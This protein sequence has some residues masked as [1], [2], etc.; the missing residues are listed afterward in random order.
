[1]LRIKKIILLNFFSLFVLANVTAQSISGVVYED[2]NN[3]GTKEANEPGI[4]GVSVSDQINIVVTD[5]NGFY[6]IVNKGYGIIFITV[7]NGYSAKTF[8]QKTSQLQINFALTKSASHSSFQFIHASDTHLSENSMDRMDKFRSVIDSVHP[9]LV[10]ITGDLVK[11]ALRVGEKEAT[12]LYELFISEA[13]K[14]KA[15]LWLAPGN[16]EIFGIERHLS[17][18]SPLNPL[19]GRK[20]Y[21]NYLGPDY[22]SFNY[23]G[24]HFIALNSLEFEDLYYYGRIDSTQMEWLKK[25]LSFLDPSTTVVTFQHVPFYSGGLSM[26]N[27]TGDGFNRAIE[28]E[29][30]VLQYRHVVSNAEEVLSILN[31]YNYV[32]AL[33]GHYHF[34]Q[35][36]FFEGSKTRFEQTAAVIA[37]SN[38]NYTTMPSGVTLYKVVSG[39]IDEGHFIPLDKK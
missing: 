3:N 22:Y 33:S 13:N 14:I 26:E 21:R 35:K 18:V 23:G 15:P 12:H 24:I 38:T 10:L 8:W 6:Q 32:L 19:Y 4:K 9:D 16:H 2:K 27:F 39:K 34:R 17:L 31:P 25:D 29:H 20:M 1:M 5:A 28:K 37:P 36:F 11:D 7:P 30:G